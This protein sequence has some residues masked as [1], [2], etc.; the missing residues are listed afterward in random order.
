MHRTMKPSLS[1][2]SAPGVV[3]SVTTRQLRAETV[4]PLWPSPGVAG[5]VAANATCARAV[6]RP[7]VCTASSHRR[8]SVPVAA[9]PRTIVPSE[10]TARVLVGQGTS[11]LL[12][13]IAES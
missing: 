11:V 3:Q 5:V 1:Q 6:L 10:R 2:V 13:V 12:S 9:S 4:V 8:A 7:W